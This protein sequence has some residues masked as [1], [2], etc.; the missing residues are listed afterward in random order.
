LYLTRFCPDRIRRQCYPLCRCIVP[1]NTP[2]WTSAAAPPPWSP[3]P[4]L[5]PPC[6]PAPSPA[7][8]PTYSNKP[9][10]TNSTTT[11]NTHFNYSDLSSVA[12]GNSLNPSDDTTTISRSNQRLTTRTLIVSNSGDLAESYIE[13]IN[14][15]FACLRLSIPTDVLKLASDPTFLQQAADTTDGIYLSLSPR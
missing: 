3:S 10:S 14:A 15:I 9:A 4:P 1:I 7:P 12:G 8:S 2:T 11:A 13:L 6:S 5:H